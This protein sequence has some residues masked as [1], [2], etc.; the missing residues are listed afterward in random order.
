MYLNLSKIDLYTYILIILYLTYIK[1][2]EWYFLIGLKYLKIYIDSQKQISEIVK[3][4]SNHQK[5]LK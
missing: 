5:Y 3:V 4:Y 1:D 2:Q